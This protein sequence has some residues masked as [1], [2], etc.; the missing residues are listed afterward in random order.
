M[1]RRPADKNV[2]LIVLMLDRSSASS[3]SCMSV[4]QIVSS[5][6]IYPASADQPMQ[7]RSSLNR[8][9][10]STYLSLQFEQNIKSW[11]SSNTGKVFEFSRIQNRE[12]LPFRLSFSITKHFDDIT[13]LHTRKAHRYCWV[14]SK[15]FR[16]VLLGLQSLID[17]IVRYT[18][19][20]WHHN[21]WADGK[22]SVTRRQ[23][24]RQPIGEMTD[25]LISNYS[26]A[27]LNI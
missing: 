11:F 8:H 1:I 3:F 24:W 15:V 26:I 22:A 25:F 14:L 4:L 10:N 12:S 5:P 18:I 9:T 13:V 17:M 27:T 19:H 6:Y 7:L 2:Q 20:S 16:E 23:Q 21:L